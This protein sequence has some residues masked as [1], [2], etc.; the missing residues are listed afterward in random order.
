M[1]KNRTYV[2]ILG[3]VVEVYGLHFA[4]REDIIADATRNFYQIATGANMNKLGRFTY[5][6]LLGFVLLGLIGLAACVPITAP[7]EAQP[8]SETPTVDTST[9]A[10]PTVE[11]ST[12]ETPE[13]KTEATPEFKV[14]DT[15]DYDFS[16]TPYY[17]KCAI[18]TART[19]QA[20]EKIET[21]VNGQRETVNVANDGDYVVRNPGGEEYIVETPRFE[22]RYTLIEGTADQYLPTGAPVQVVELDENVQFVAPWGETQYILAGGYLIHNGDEVYGIQRQEF[23][24]TYAPSTADGQFVD[25]D[26][27][28]IAVLDVKCG[29]NQP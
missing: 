4:K 25:A 3:D 13:V 6:M 1:G 2:L 15:G 8:V 27:K 16:G 28:P 21:I 24:D 26:G 10:T 11:A 22:S 20:G 29:A 17:K 23:L 7:Q 12:V 5:V 14:I 19:A 9:V 18:V